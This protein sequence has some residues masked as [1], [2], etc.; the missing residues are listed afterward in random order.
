MHAPRH[1][2]RSD[3]PRRRSPDRTDGAGKAGPV[4]RQRQSAPRSQSGASRSTRDQ[5]EIGR[6]SMKLDISLVSAEEVRS[7][8][9]LYRHEMSCQIIHDSWHA[10]GWVDSYLLR[11]DDRVV[12]YGLVGGVRADPKDTITEFYV[13]P[14]HRGAALPLFRRLIDVG[15][16]AKIEAQTNDVLLT[17]MLF[18]CAVHI[19]RNEVL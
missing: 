13:L 18:D 4:G 1:S 5:G 7:M 11:L 12:G 9:D 19:E 2:G 14:P 3:G 6:I 10:R 8:R 17:L 16:A 15:R